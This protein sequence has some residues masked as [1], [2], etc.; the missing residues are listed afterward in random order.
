MQQ[1]VKFRVWGF[2]WSLGFGAQGLG[3]RAFGL[4][5]RVGV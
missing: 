2:L 4:G 1:G 5:F 3:F